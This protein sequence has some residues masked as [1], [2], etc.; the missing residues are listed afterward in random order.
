MAG[1]WLW[2]KGRLFPTGE[3]TPQGGIISPVLANL[4]LLLPQWLRRIA[5]GVLSAAVLALLGLN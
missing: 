4:T 3:D 5:F 2:E 1:R